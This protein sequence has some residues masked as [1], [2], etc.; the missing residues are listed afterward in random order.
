MAGAFFE[1]I[2]E[3]FAD[4]AFVVEMGAAELGEGFVVGLDRDVVG[5]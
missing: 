3:G 1:E 4:V 2:A 5:L